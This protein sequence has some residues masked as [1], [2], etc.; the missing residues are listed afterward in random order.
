[1]I[2]REIVLEQIHH[3]ETSPVPYTL[4]F[5]GDVEERLDAC[6]GTKDWRKRLQTYI[7]WTGV[8]LLYTSPSPRD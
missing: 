8:C 1:M 5:E 3:H 6:Y 7:G 4:L 2:P